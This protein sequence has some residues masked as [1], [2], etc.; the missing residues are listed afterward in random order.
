[1]KVLGILSTKKGG[2]ITARSNQTIR[3]AVAVLTQHNIGALVIVND[4]GK[5][6]G[7]LS[8]RDIV[9]QAAKPDDLFSLPIIHVMTRSVIVARPQDDLM[10]VAHTMTEK[11]FRHMPILDDEDNLIGMISIGDVLKA[12]RDQYRGE[13]D[14]LETLV[15][16]DED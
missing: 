11:R 3:D 12:Q 8:E 13:I 14:T 4:V 5:L 9:R 7:I 10:S 6:V 16:A 2:V 1:M 15:M